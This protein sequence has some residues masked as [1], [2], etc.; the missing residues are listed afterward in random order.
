VSDFRNALKKLVHD[1]LEK[2]GQLGGYRI[3]TVTEVNDDGTVTF[4]IDGTGAAAVAVLPV[5][6]GQ[7][8]L[9]VPDRTG[10]YR[11]APIKATVPTP[12]DQP[13]FLAGGFMRFFGL[14]SNFGGNGAFLQDAFSS[15]VYQIL[16][17]DLVGYIPRGGCLSPDGTRCCVV[18]WNSNFEG[19]FQLTPDVHYR[20]YDLGSA[21]S[22]TKTDT[23]GLF[24]SKAMMLFEV[25][26]N[27]YNWTI[28]GLPTLPYS[29][30]LADTHDAGFL[31]DTVCS[32][33]NDKLNLYWAELQLL[34]ESLSTGGDDSGFDPP[35]LPNGTPTQNINLFKFVNS[36][37]SM[38][39]K[40]TMIGTW[41]TWFVS[42]NVQ[43]FQANPS[44]GYNAA[45]LQCPRSVF[46]LECIN[47]LQYHSGSYAVGMIPAIV[48]PTASEMI[49]SV[50]DPLGTGS[51]ATD[52]PLGGGL[53]ITPPPPPVP[54]VFAKL[55]FVAPDD[56]ESAAAWDTGY[57]FHFNDANAGEGPFELIYP[58]CS[59]PLGPK[60][61][62]TGDVTYSRSDGGV[63]AFRSGNI[64]H[65]QSFSAYIY[66]GIDPTSG[67]AP[68]NGFGN[69][70][71]DFI[72]VMFKNL[73]K[74]TYDVARF[75][76]SISMDPFI[77]HGL[78]SL[79][80]FRGVMLMMKSTSQGW[81]LDGSARVR[82]VTGDSST[83]KLLFTADTDIKKFL[84]VSPSK[85]PTVDQTVLLLSPICAVST[86]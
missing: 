78:S 33:D 58:A 21:L 39:S 48:D 14:N 34:P 66:D 30:A 45:F 22:G 80:P 84:K 74:G 69:S 32:L 54:F 65:M 3:G 18:W 23:V 7:E 15:N 12:F 42:N 51:L 26:R 68:G 2:R 44:L 52:V 9:V 36:T 83:G 50:S 86:L 41:N 37:P 19:E 57:Q 20:V 77:N 46:T 5:I 11:V 79:A 10:G 76:N 27:L 47:G 85:D 62:L 24:T 59:I 6:V 29:I 35:L 72:S 60:I 75:T 53:L 82:K 55:V 38:P 4:S 13:P 17:P 70:D 25:V 43:H 49:G 16:A 64:T 1:E 28:V 67:P 40:T 56:S 71:L 63:T 8:V 81:L 73:E 31:T 61:N